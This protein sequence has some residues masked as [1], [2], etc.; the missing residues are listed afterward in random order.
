[1]TLSTEDLAM[2][3]LALFRDRVK[4]SPGGV[5]YK[6]DNLPCDIGGT[7]Y[8]MND[9]ETRQCAIG[10]NYLLS[11]GHVAI[12]YFGGTKRLVISDSGLTAEPQL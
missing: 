10:L 9:C 5:F 1:M 12:D 11:Q 8:K 7:R 3:M 6:L 4:G 2:K